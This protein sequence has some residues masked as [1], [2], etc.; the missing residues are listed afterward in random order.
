MLLSRVTKTLDFYEYIKSPVVMKVI[1][2]ELL[3]DTNKSSIEN[4]SYMDVL[5]D[6]V[7]SVEK[8]FNDR[9]NIYEKL[10]K[11][12]ITE[13]KIQ[14]LSERKSNLCKEHLDNADKEI[15]TMLQVLI[16]LEFHFEYAEKFV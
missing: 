2:Y 6:A 7:K 1:L 9:K 12:G 8:I 15:L 10:V 13:R 5:K 16:Y 4:I 3:K 14:A 11:H